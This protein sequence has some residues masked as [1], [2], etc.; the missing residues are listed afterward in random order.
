MRRAAIY[1]IQRFFVIISFGVLAV[2]ILL[3]IH[4]FHI[5]LAWNDIP[6]TQN[7][8]ISLPIPMPKISESVAII[9]GHS[10]YDSGATCVDAAGNTTL[11]EASI[12]A[13]IADRVAEILRN[14]G[15]SVVILQEYD[16]RLSNLKA[17]LLLSLHSDS[18]INI[19]GYKAASYLYSAIPD[20]DARLVG[21]IDTNYSAVTGLTRNADT[22][23]HNMTEYHAFHK[24]DPPTPS[25]ILELGFI[26]GD[27]ELLTTHADMVANGVAQSLR[28]FLAGKDATPPPPA[29]TT[30]AD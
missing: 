27:R 9:A 10:G 21:C 19:S 16:P 24:I 12:N 2:I 8:S 1:R 5:G 14:E 11:T 23:T 13:N 29:T 22:I 4:I 25:A 3:S 7:I 26:G 20:E 28:C 6:I 17:D 18:C 15:T 30:P